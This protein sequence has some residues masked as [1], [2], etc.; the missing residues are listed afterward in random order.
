MK[1]VAKKFN[2]SARKGSLLDRDGH[3]VYG[4]AKLNFSNR[5]NNPTW[6]ETLMIR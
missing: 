5:I 6:D 3:T 4:P 1:S 2:R